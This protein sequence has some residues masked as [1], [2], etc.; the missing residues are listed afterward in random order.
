MIFTNSIKFP[1]IFNLST[2][3]TDIEEQYNSINK[4]L[5]LLLTTAKG[6]LLGDPNFGCSL[7]EQL[8][9][10]YVEKQ[11]DIIIKEI[12]DSISKY[13][14]RVLVNDTDINIEEDTEDRHTYIIHISYK[15]RN[16]NLSNTTYVNISEE[17]INN[18]G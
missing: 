11:K 8:F 3:D 7:Y 2:G 4:C 12:V 6:E 5:A 17:D 10:P 14:K 18:R 13:E 9:N 15:L 1:N 16:S